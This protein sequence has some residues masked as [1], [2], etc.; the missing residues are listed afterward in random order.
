MAVAESLLLEQERNSRLRVIEDNNMTD[1][2]PDDARLRATEAQMRR[3]LGLGSDAP[4]QASDR[5]TPQ[6]TPSAHPQKRRFVRDGDVPVTVVHR[7]HRQDDPTGGNQ[8]EQARQ[9][10]RAQAAAREKAERLLDEAQARIRDL[11][12][13]LAHERLARDEAVQRVAAEKQALEQ[14]VQTAREELATEREAVGRA[15]AALAAAV[16]ARQQAEQ[17]LRDVMRAKQAEA[18]ASTRESPPRITRRAKKTAEDAGTPI[19]ANQD[20]GTAE[21][22]QDDSTVVEWWKPG[23]RK[24]FR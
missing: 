1:S 14:A 19:A 22:E 24:R 15:N 3:A 6:A 8:L 2:L 5:A 20:R 18:S 4:S 13:K 21:P 9:A 16:D 11:E 7:D 12:T 17:R 10:I 23:W